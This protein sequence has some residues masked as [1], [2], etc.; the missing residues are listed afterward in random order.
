MGEE[1]GISETS[2]ESR[3]CVCVLTCESVHVHLCAIYV[4]K[5]K[6]KHFKVCKSQV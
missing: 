1:M 4:K 2:D 5:E 3:L 6:K